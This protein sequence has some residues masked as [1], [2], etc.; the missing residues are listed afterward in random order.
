MSEDELDKYA[1]NAAEFLWCTVGD[2]AHP[3]LVEADF[4]DALESREDSHFAFQL[5]DVDGDGFVMESE[6]H[7]RFE[8]IYRCCNAVLHFSIEV[9]EINLKRNYFRL[10]AF[11]DP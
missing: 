2:P 1:H 8:A 9:P 3:K 7:Q 10:L 5:F 6:V 11:P 4:E